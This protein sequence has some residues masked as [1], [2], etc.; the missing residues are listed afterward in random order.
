MVM[1][2]LFSLLSLAFISVIL[3]HSCTSS[4]EGGVNFQLNA[5]EFSERIS[6][7]TDAVILDVRTAG[8]FSQGHLQNATNISWNN[9]TFDGKINNIKKDSPIFVYCGLAP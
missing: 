1:N 7:T 4:N 8:E 9:P 5:Q 3:I 2:N 6:A